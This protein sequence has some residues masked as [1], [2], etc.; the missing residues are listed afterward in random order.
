MFKFNVYSMV[1]QDKHQHSFSGEVGRTAK[2]V[3][4]KGP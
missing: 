3:I 1:L 2:V 4:F